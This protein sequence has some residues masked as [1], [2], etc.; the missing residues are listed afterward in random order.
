MY[1]CL[2]NYP[3][4]MSI[5]QCCNWILF[6]CF[7]CFFNY[8][9]TRFDIL[10][11]LSFSEH[12]Q[13]AYQ[14]LKTQENDPELKNLDPNL[15]SDIEQ[16]LSYAINLLIKVASTINLSAIAGTVKACGEHLGLLKICFP[17]CG[18]NS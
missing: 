9:S 17:G 18:A 5:V 14:Q 12:L 16:K 3:V 2:F 6:H 4:V 7:L 15:N 1:L 13:Q 10:K 8:L 11:I